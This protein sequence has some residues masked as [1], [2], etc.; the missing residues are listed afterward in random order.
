MRLALVSDIHANFD[1]L[2]A[3]ADLLESADRVVCLGDCVG[4]YRQVNEV[5]DY[6]R[7]LEPVCVLG[8]HDL[9]ALTN[10]PPTANPAVRAGVEHAAATMTPQNRA[11][12]GSLPAMWAGRL[13]GALVL[14]AHGSP[15]RPFDDYLYAGDGRL[16]RLAEFEV[17]LVALGQTHRAFVSAEGGPRVVSP[18]SVGQ[19]RD[20]PGSASVVLLD[21]TDMDP[22]LVRRPVE[23][24]DAPEG[25]A[26][27][28]RG[29]G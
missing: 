2:A 21:T 7:R 13:G 4:Y 17:D 6:L 15:W 11:W 23:P 5:L 27:P 14:A 16:P 24:G 9:F 1:A 12:L 22:V 28:G 29:E 20:L 19:P 10:C 3:V 26:G 18:G 8:N 25:T